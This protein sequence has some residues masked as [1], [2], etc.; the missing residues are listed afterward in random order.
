MPAPILLQLP[1]EFSTFRHSIFEKML[2]NL[3]E[4]NSRVVKVNQVVTDIAAAS[5]QQSEG[6]EEISS[7]I[8]QMNQI[9]QQTAANSE[10]SAS[11]SEELSTQANEIA[12]MVDGFHLSSTKKTLLPGVHN[13]DAQFFD[14]PDTDDPRRPAK[15][16]ST[17]RPM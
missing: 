10:E 1:L 2:T 9:T 11:A 3:G 8:E 15:K 14:F 4:I 7:A 17:L 16:A 13:S 12:S 5:E 6:V